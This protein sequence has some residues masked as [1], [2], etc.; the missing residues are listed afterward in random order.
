MFVVKYLEVSNKHTT[1]FSECGDS[2]TDLMPRASI[3]GR[4]KN[5]FLFSKD[6]QAG[7]GTHPA[8]Y[9]LGTALLSP[10]VRWWV[11]AVDHSHLAPSYTSTL[12]VLFKI[13]AGTT[14]HFS[15]IL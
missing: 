5:N 7:S 9:L 1:T 12:P 11:R 13:W 15:F 10:G 4:R 8:S 3:T 14:L 2:T 6:V